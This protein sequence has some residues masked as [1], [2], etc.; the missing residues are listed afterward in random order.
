MAVGIFSLHCGMWD[1][2]LWNAVTEMKCAFDGLV[3]G[4]DRAEERLWAW[5]KVK[6]KVASS[7]PALCNPKDYTVHG[8]LQ[9]R[10]LELVAFP[11]SR[12]S[13]P[14]QRLNPGLLHRLQIVYQ[15]SYNRSLRI[16]E[17]VAYPFSSRS[18][19][20]KGKTRVS[21]VAGAFF[22]TWAMKEAL[23]NKK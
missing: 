7:C 9:A 13:S 21:C 8:I 2:V 3:N 22:T 11:F 4:L 20:P 18:S 23:K 12:G 1:L 19:Q 17:W 10:I 6:A 14:T 5:K 15:L 16:L